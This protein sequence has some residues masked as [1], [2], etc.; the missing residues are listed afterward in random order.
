MA[1]GLAMGGDS[2]WRLRAAAGDPVSVFDPATGM[3]TSAA[4]NQ[5]LLVAFGAAHRSV[6]TETLRGEKLTERFL[7]I[8]EEYVA[9]RYPDRSA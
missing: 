3:W 7:E 6:K 1:T 2:G 4:Y 5:P 8:I 9:T